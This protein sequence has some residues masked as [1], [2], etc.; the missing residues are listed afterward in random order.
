LI[1][2]TCLLIAD[3]VTLRSG[4]ETWSD[5]KEPSQRRSGAETSSG[6]KAPS[7]RR[8]GAETSSDPKAPLQLRSGAETSS[9]PKAPS[10]LRSE[11]GTWSDP[12]EPSQ[13][14][15]EPLQQ[16]SVAEISS[17]P[18]ALHS[19]HTRTQEEERKRRISRQPTYAYSFV[20][21]LAVDTTALVLRFVRV[22]QIV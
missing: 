9:D 16:C 1:N 4:A 8:S 14:L 21:L 5:P 22:T 7:Q 10:Q 2:R 3:F 6:P 18:K 15:A 13:P 20:S 12:K 11:A 19:Q 17:D